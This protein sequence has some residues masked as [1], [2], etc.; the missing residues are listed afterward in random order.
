MSKTIAF[1]LYGSRDSYRRELAL[2]LLSA[3]RWQPRDVRFCVVTDQPEACFAGLPIEHVSITREMLDDWTHAGRSMHRAKVC[4]LEVA[5]NLHGGRV[6]LVDTDTVFEANPVL[7]FERIDARRSLLH[8][9]EQPVGALPFWRELL[10]RVQASHAGEVAGFRVTPD[11][12]M[13][14]S[15]VIGIDACHVAALGRALDLIDAL[16]AI[17]RV[18]NAE[19]YA[20]ASALAQVTEIGTCPDLVRHYWGT[21]RTFVHVQAERLLPEPLAESFARRLRENAPL[22]LGIPPKAVL[23]KVRARAVA[24]VFGWNEEV[25]FAYLAALCARRSWARD[26]KMADAWAEVSVQALE[27]AQ[28][29]RQ[30]EKPTSLLPFTSFAPKRLNRLTWLSDERRMRW[31]HFWND[32]ETSRATRLQGRPS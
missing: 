28:N 16:D 2:S 10:S 32:V 14:N 23:D 24:R 22:V 25:R 26:P 15:G 4:A 27:R 5:A 19:Q 1:L 6:V 18:F 12:V 7:L 31:Q 13:F 21:D 8:A 9:R 3:R 17:G 30:L 29:D 11:D 20:V